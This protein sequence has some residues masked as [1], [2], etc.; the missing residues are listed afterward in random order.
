MRIKILTTGG[1]IDKVYFDAKS[2]YEVG[3]PQ[4]VEILKEAH[5]TLD[6]QVESLLSKDSLEMTEEDRQLIRRR[7]EADPCRGS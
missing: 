7:V 1:T 3:P 4:V 6:C 2:E 5:V